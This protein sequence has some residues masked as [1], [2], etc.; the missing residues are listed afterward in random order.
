MSEPL[1]DLTTLLPAECIH[2]DL[3]GA[4]AEAVLMELSARVPG[5][6]PAQR[7]ELAA[8][9][10][11]REKIHSTG[12]GDGV[13]LPHTRE[14]LAGVLHVPV[15]VMGRTVAPIDFHAIDAKPVQLFFLILA[16]NLKEHLGLLARLSRM[17]RR[18][19]V[20][21]ALLTA[22]DAAAVMQIIARAQTQ[23]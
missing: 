3:V 12:V 22:T 10:L 18:P 14:A 13:A 7:D 15:I 20:R 21:K 19:M 16:T 4:D 5:L 1:L 17:L 23:R 6:T 11:A 2:L 8:A 9:L